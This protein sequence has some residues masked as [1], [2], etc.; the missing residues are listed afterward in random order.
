MIVNID[1][2][3]SMSARKSPRRGWLYNMR[4]S[5]KLFF[6]D[7]SRRNGHP[8]GR[9]KEQPQAF[10]ALRGLP[11][12]SSLIVTGT[13]R[14]EPRSQGGFEMGVTKVE[15]VQRVADS[16]PYPIQLKEH[17]VDFLRPPPSLDSHPARRSILRIR[18]EVIRA[19]REYSIG[20]TTRSPTRP[21]F[22]PAAC[23]GTTTLFEVQHVD[24]ESLSHAGLSG[25][26]IGFHRRVSRKGISGPTFRASNSRT[27]AASPNS[28]ARAGSLLRAPEEDMLGEGLVSHVVHTVVR[29]RPRELETLKRDVTKLQTVKT[30]FPRL[31]YDEAVEILQKVKTPGSGAMISAAMR[32]PSSPASSTARLRFIATPHPSRPST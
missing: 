9:T 13:I 4:E 26:Y 14:A 24:E 21:S 16:D 1:Q 12:E 2:V 23:E 6:P 10:E 31:T 8:A 30:P 7:F 3:K 18:A 20:A 27:A 32:K 28:D 17:G 11:Q 25:F 19:A 15:I 5:G 22:T 29:K